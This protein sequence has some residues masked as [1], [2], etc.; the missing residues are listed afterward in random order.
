VSSSHNVRDPSSFVRVVNFGT[1]EYTE[2]IREIVEDQI[3]WDWVVQHWKK[4]SLNSG[5]DNFQ[6]NY[7]PSKGENWETQTDE[8]I[9]EHGG[10]NLP[11]VHDG[12]FDDSTKELFA[13]G[14]NIARELKVPYAD[15]AYDPGEDE[16]LFLLR[17]ELFCK[18][19][20]ANNV[21][22]ALTIL[23]SCVGEINEFN[24]IGFCRDASLGTGVTT[25]HKDDGNCPV[26]PHFM[27]VSR[28]VVIGN[29]VVRV[30]VLFYMRKTAWEGTLRRQACLE[31]EWML[32]DWAETHEEYLY[33]GS[34][35][36]AWHENCGS[37]G[38]QT[39]VDASGNLL[40][41]ALVS[42]AHGSKVAH[43]L[44]TFVEACRY[45]CEK[46]PLLADFHS[47]VEMCLYAGFINNFLPASTA[48]RDLADTP[49][50]DL[51][52]IPSEG[53]V[54]LFTRHQTKLFGS[55]YSGP[56]P[57][58]SAF[59]GGTPLAP[60]DL[61]AFGLQ[62][63]EI[64]KE[65]QK[66]EEEG[67]NRQSPQKIVEHMYSFLRRLNCRAKGAGMFTLNHV[68]HATVALGLNKFVALARVAVPGKKSGDDQS[69]YANTSWHRCMYPAVPKSN[70]KDPNREKTF[71]LKAATIMRCV[72]IYIT[73]NPIMP[74]HPVEWEALENIDC[75]CTRKDE[76]LECRLPFDSTFTHYTSPDGDYSLLRHIPVV[77]RDGGTETVV[78]RTADN[79][80]LLEASEYYPATESPLWKKYPTAAQAMEGST[81]LASQPVIPVQREITYVP[82]AIWGHLIPREEFSKDQWARLK[83][84]FAYDPENPC[85][86]RDQLRKIMLIPG[87]KDLN[88]ISLAR[89]ALAYAFAPSSREEAAGVTA[90]QKREAHVRRLTS[91]PWFPLTAL[92]EATSTRRT[93]GQAQRIL[94][95][96][97]AEDRRSR[98]MLRKRAFERLSLGNVRRT[99]PRVAPALAL[100]PTVLAIEPTIAQAAAVVTPIRQP[101]IAGVHAG[102]PPT[103]NGK[104][105]R[106]HRGKRRNRQKPVVNTT[107][108]KILATPE[109]LDAMVEEEQMEEAQEVAAEI[110]RVTDRIPVIGGPTSDVLDAAVARKTLGSPGPTPDVLHAALAMKDLMTTSNPVNPSPYASRP[111]QGPARL[112]N[113]QTN[114]EPNALWGGVGLYDELLSQEFLLLEAGEEDQDMDNGDDRKAAADDTNDPNPFA[115]DMDDQTPPADGMDD[116]KPAPDDMDDRKPAAQNMTSR[117]WHHPAA[118]VLEMEFG[119]VEPVAE[120]YSVRG[121]GGD[122]TG[123]HDRK[124]AAVPMPS[125]TCRDWPA[126]ESQP[127]P[128]QQNQRW[129][130]PLTDMEPVPVYDRRPPAD[131]MD[132]RKPA[133]DTMDDRKP[134]PRNTTSRHWHRP[135]APVREMEFP[136]AEPVAQTYS[137]RGHGGDHTGTDDRKPPPVAMA[138]ETSG[139]WQVQQSQQWPVQQNQGWPVAL[140]DMEP[141]PVN[142]TFQQCQHWPVTVTEIEFGDAKPIARIYPDKASQ[143]AVLLEKNSM[144]IQKQRELLTKLNG[145]I[146]E[147][148][149]SIKVVGSHISRHILDVA[150]N[151]LNA[152]L[153]KNEHINKYIKTMALCDIHFLRLRVQAGGWNVLEEVVIR[154]CPSDQQMKLDEGGDRYLYQAEVRDKTGCLY[155]FNDL[156]RC[157]LCE[158]IGRQHGCVSLLRLNSSGAP[159]MMAFSSPQQ[160]LVHYLT[161]LIF[162]VPPQPF[163]VK[164]GD[165]SRKRPTRNMRQQQPRMSTSA[166][167]NQ[168]A[169]SQDL[170]KVLG[171]TSA[172]YIGDDGVPYMYI[173]GKKNPG[174]D[175]TILFAIPHWECLRFC[176]KTGRAPKRKGGPLAV[177]GIALNDTEVVY[178]IP[179]NLVDTYL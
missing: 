116:C 163:Y 4:K 135:A 42:P 119:D 155:R 118:P 124:S 61:R 21:L 111:A 97:E 109:E 19:M 8:H 141:V 35:P 33:P 156:G 6:V 26:R 32:K 139:D 105:R 154:G 79:P 40:L 160:A 86:Y 74:N 70:T 147:I 104:R 128:V 87:F 16:R 91:L 148:R 22:E 68:I 96:P 20:G 73:K 130:L 102:F 168:V 52:F 45:F 136:N 12:T 170:W 50:E 57:R 29:L 133:G 100:E 37:H 59:L 166:R 127:W 15:P 117:H 82:D 144:P 66:A 31:T 177:N 10:C 90:A 65:C 44:P 112:D 38:V 98:A 129:P 51:N 171:F 85:T 2:P 150:T 75:E 43:H 125:E 131:D 17:D 164:Q 80:P 95:Q 175:N 145:T 178:I 92:T 137:V 77:V 176:A 159:N 101:G 169:E 114:F 34:D 60:S 27:N 126:E 143:S 161:C 47:L 49:F 72:S 63:V 121:R 36:E 106:K 84:L 71:V 103:R 138:S 64:I 62:L 53:L 56:H 110:N 174:K 78:F 67:R 173:F 108:I 3:D 158:T 152:A 94:W 151:A 107:A 132:D 134:A 120:I 146:N 83:I 24:Q 41:C 1:R 18:R 14:S 81:A 93:W 123:M 162:T 9:S 39:C 89:H 58:C 140:T 5:R 99:P 28:L 23:F 113:Q 122:D 55:L 46:Q 157:L 179:R 25:E 153:P 69:I 115:D 142:M 30:S 11:K 167:N 13:A 54:G 76:K 48:I 165:K 172:G 7:G 149:P 88:D